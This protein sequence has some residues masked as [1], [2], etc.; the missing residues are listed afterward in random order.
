[1]PSGQSGKRLSV[2][3]GSMNNPARPLADELRR[4]AAAEFDF[5][6][7]TA[8]PPGA[9]PFDPP[10]VRA[11]LAE[12]GLGV[13]GHTAYYLPIASPFAALRASAHAV[14]IETL[15][16][17]AAV[18]A[19]AVNVHPDPVGKLFWPDDIRDR[20]AQAVAELAEQAQARGVTLMLENLGRFG[21]VEDLA[22][23]FDAA[24]AAAFHLDAGHANLARDR[25]EPNRAAALIAA[26]GD[27]LA[28]V[29]VSDNNGI[30]DLHLP[31]GAG[32]VDWLAVIAALKGSGYDGTVTLEVFAPERAL[33][34]QSR[35]LWL[36][37][38]DAV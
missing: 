32:N 13:V 38:W 8:E 20:N 22:P 25:D 35:R 6:D 19:T 3:I 28:H 10:A 11:L 34:E 2:L 36:D 24:P 23:V 21:R 12:L 7:L 29:H 4:I 14:L 30:D 16:A 9:W 37:W 26:F 27:R 31:L 18:G 5:V 1:M 15:D 33:L 17:L